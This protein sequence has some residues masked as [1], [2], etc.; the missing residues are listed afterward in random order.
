M[1][2]MEMC[3][4]ESDNTDMRDRD[5]ICQWGMQGKQEASCLWG[6]KK[7]KKLHFH[8]CSQAYV[9]QPGKSL[10]DGQFFGDFLLY[11]ELLH[12]HELTVSAKI[13]E[14]RRNHLWFIRSALFGNFFFLLSTFLLIQ[15]LIRKWTDEAYVHL[16]MA[17]DQIRTFS[18]Q[19]V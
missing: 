14:R 5:S 8:A 6:K 18:K 1:R 12:V 11:I 15:D 10:L 13:K 16:A 3:Q 2:D 9:G 17:F 7:K 19:H 4:E